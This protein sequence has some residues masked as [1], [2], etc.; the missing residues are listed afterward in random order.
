[1]VVVHKLFH[2]T[3]FSMVPARDFPR[4]SN[5]LR[6]E[7]GTAV[8]EDWLAKGKEGGIVLKKESTSAPHIAYCLRQ[9]NFWGSLVASRVVDCIKNNDQC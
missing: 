8:P 3:K 5:W 2:K 9:R 4:E 7:D 6:R 1:M